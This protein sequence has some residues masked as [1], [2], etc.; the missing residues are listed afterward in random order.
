VLELVLP[1]VVG[2]AIVGECRIK[3]RKE[4]DEQVL[5]QTWT[6]GLHWSEDYPAWLHYCK[7]LILQKKNYCKALLDFKRTV[8]FNFKSRG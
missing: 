4:R 5:A 6:G 1:V 3:M 7:A 8:V 2:E